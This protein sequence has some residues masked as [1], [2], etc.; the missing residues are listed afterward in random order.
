ML[1]QTSLIR[2]YQSSETKRADTFGETIGSLVESRGKD[3]R[4]K[5]LYWE[6][7]NDPTVPEDGFV[8]HISSPSYPS[9]LIRLLLF[10]FLF[11]FCISAHSFLFVED[12]LRAVL[13]T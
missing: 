13:V 12:E 7:K 10:L 8:C 9:S 4:L 1:L 3:A 6:L 5:N 2:R 11:L